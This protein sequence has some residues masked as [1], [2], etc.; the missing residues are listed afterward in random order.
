[1]QRRTLKDIAIEASEKTGVSKQDAVKMHDVMYK[2]TMDCLAN[3]DELSRI[4]FFGFNI[5][6]HPTTARNLLK[7]GKFTKNLLSDLQKIG[8]KKKLSS[9][10]VQ[11]TKNIYDRLNKIHEIV[12][13]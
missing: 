11:I 13:E 3:K 10:R 7:A 6:V 9:K 5:R 12:Q 4:Q 2:M 1:M 8:L